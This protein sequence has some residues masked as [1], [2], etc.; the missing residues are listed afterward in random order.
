MSNTTNTPPIT[1]PQP[2]QPQR[3]QQ[4]ERKG[5]LLACSSTWGCVPVL[6]SG[7]VPMLIFHVKQ[8]E[9]HY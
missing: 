7:G 9:Q 3:S 4:F 8:Y 6:L 1:T 2:Q 5:Q